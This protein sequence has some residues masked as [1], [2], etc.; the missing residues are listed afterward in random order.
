M[1]AMDN[2]KSTFVYVKVHR[3][4]GDRG[5]GTCPVLRGGPGRIADI[6]TLQDRKTE[7]TLALHVE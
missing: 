1:R 2:G 7:E 5:R 4:T 3:G 6:S